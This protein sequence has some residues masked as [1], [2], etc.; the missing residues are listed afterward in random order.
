MNV[1]MEPDKNIQLTVLNPQLEEDEIVIDLREIIDAMKRFFVLW[2]VFSIVVGGILGGVGI[3]LRR[4]YHVSDATA[5]IEYSADEETAALVNVS[6]LMAPS[7]I[8][9]AM[10]NLNL[11]TETLDDVRTSISLTGVMSDDTYDK[12][13]LYYD[14][15][16]LN[17]ANLTTVDTIM[18]V[19]EKP[20]RYI[21]TLDY[22]GAGLDRQTGIQ[23]LDEI[24]KSYRKY[25]DRTYNAN[26]AIGN[27]VSVVDYTS[28]D[29]AEAV[30]V[31][32]RVLDDAEEYLESVS[33]AAVDENGEEIPG[34]QFRSTVTGYK[35]SD[36]QKSVQLIKEIELNRAA[37]FV[38]V[39]SVTVN[40]TNTEAARYEWLIEQETREKSV[41]ESTLQSLTKSIEAYQKD[42][43]VYTETV[44]S[45]EEEEEK[46]VDAYDSMI[47]KKI[48]LQDQISELNTSIRYNQS[49]IE[50]LNK[51]K[52]V[53]Q[54]NL[55]IADEY[56]AS[57]YEK[58][59]R[60]MNSV[61]E[62]MDE[63]FEK[64][65]KQNTLMILVPATARA[66]KITD[67]WLKPVL[68]AEAIV[69]LL[70][71]AYAAV[72]AINKMN[73]RKVYLDP[74]E[75]KRFTTADQ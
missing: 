25:F 3:L 7:I 63:Y 22:M 11:D 35:I 66:P 29:Y 51:A 19:N 34:L 6:D 20:T 55:E 75:T 60:L 36:L 68:I 53:Q 58:L 43:V 31:F 4:S 59:T 8:E 28:Y 73:P 45:E 67:R 65:V 18:S 41:L 33:G 64:A 9:E 42:P 54:E 10:K 1:T 24:L 32:S 69:F 5:L 40:D 21:V 70:Y 13:T 49:V 37:S 30:N 26:V 23:L 15:L 62:T 17:T 44:K 57:F 47:L 48:E 14:L 52:K 56:M 39:N 72:Y 46:K 74:V 61:N 71:I 27:A 2:L 16:S 38:D 50:K 12:V